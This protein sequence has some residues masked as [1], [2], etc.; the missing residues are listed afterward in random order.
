MR[1]CAVCLVL[2]LL[3][4]M[5]LLWGAE[6]D[7]AIPPATH[8]E[9]RTIGEANSLRFK[10]LSTFCLDANE[11][12]LACDSGASD[13]KVVSPDGKVQGVWKL[14]FKPYAIHHCPD[15]TVYVGGKG[16]LATLDRAGKVVRKVEAKDGNFPDQKVSGLTVT[17]KHVFAAFGRGW[18]TRSQ[19]DLY[20]FDLD[21]S[22]PK[23]IAKDLRACCQRCDLV[24]RNGFVYVAENSRRRVVKYDSEGKLI[25]SWGRASRTD[26]EGFGSCC[27]PM[28]LC[29]GADGSLYTSESGLGRVKRYT[30]DGKFLGVVGC[31]GTARFSRAGGLAASCSN[32]A[33]AVSKDG[34]RVYVQ[35]VQKNLIRVLEAVRPTTQPAKGE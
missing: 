30:P 14:D 27:N 11:N 6:D 19:S 20:R 7:G 21:F 24:S 35:D 18:S 15:S 31:V 9:T 12:L 5:P 3:L 17:D 8:S 26:V 2:G 16:V 32:I 29:F 1:R 34:R 33:I 28:N 23:A 10:S 22:N 4:G 13:I 25:A